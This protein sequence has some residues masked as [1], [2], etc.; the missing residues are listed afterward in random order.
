R[1]DHGS[2]DSFVNGKPV[3]QQILNNGDQLLFG[4]TQMI[5][6]AN[7]GTQPFQ[8]PSS[9]GRELLIGRQQDPSST[10]IAR[11]QVANVRGP[12]IINSLEVLPEMTIGRSRECDFFLDDLTVSR[13]HAIIKELSN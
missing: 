2:G 3:T 8:L 4:N 13:R 1:D 6:Y 11:L 9:R 7:E 12:A 5:F 10:T